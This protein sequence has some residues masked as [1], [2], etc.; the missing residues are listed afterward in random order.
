MQSRRKAFTLVELLVVIGIIALLISILLPAMNSARRQ[1]RS[2]KCL[3]NLRS[4]GQALSLYAANN[5]RFYPIA[6]HK[7]LSATPPLEQRWHDRLTPYIT[8]ASKG[9]T[10]VTTTGDAAA[11]R[12]S[13]V[14][15]GCPEWADKDTYSYASTGYAMQ[16]FPASPT[17]NNDDPKTRALIDNNPATAGRYYRADQWGIKGSDRLVIADAMVDYLYVSIATNGTPAGQ[18][19]QRTSLWGPFT[20]PITNAD[21]WVDASRHAKPGI[22]KE[23]TYTGKYMNALFADG[24]AAPVSV[25]EAWQAIIAPGLDTAGG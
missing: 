1:A 25:R 17:A 11:L 9:D 5:Q 13:S 10:A 7:M 16:V 23:A 8:S 3:A 22:T 18:V 20:T 6:R 21:F 4:V 14:I 24:H 19:I 12:E 2:L 15:W